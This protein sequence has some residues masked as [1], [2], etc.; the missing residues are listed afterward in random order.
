MAGDPPSRLT[1]AGSRRLTSAARRPPIAQPNRAIRPQAPRAQRSPS[2]QYRSRANA[3]ARSAAAARRHAIRGAAPASSS[4]LS[5]SPRVRE[6][7][8]TGVGTATPRA[9]IPGTRSPRFTPAPAVRVDRRADGTERAGRARRRLPVAIDS[10][11]GAL[12]ARLG[13]GRGGA[14]RGLADGVRAGPAGDHRQPRRRRRQ[15]RHRGG[16]AR[17][18]GWLHAAVRRHAARRQPGPGK[19]QTRRGP[20]LRART[21]AR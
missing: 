5:V 7:T 20:G 19:R 9:T 15:H 17:G 6:A 14:H 12:S 21:G 1:V 2:L 10:G 18:E 16:W 8:G 11:R 3:D 4:P 13:R